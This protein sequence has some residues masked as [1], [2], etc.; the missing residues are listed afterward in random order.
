[1]INKIFLGGTCNESTWSKE[2]ERMLDIILND[3]NT[4]NKPI[5]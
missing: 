1:M 2:D 5:R 4:G 3:I